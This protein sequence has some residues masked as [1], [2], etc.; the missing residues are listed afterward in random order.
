MFDCVIPTR[1]AR[2]AV[3]YTFQGRMRV[4]NKR[5]RKD[6]LPPDTTCPCYTCTHF[7]RAYLHHLFA[8]EE[9]TGTAL[10]CIHNISFLQQLMAR[11]RG[12]IEEDRFEEKK[13]E[14][15]ANYGTSYGPGARPSGRLQ[16]SP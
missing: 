6:R 9:V 10:A 14:F 1:H 13:E 16:D 15:F 3:L 11:I 12:A 5:F 7:S 2:G 8:S 4:S